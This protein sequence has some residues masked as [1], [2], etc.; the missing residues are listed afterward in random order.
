ML[1]DFGLASSRSD[2]RATRTG[3]QLG[4]L[5][6]MAPEALR[7]EPLDARSDVYAL[8]VTLYELL[9]LSPPYWAK[10]GE[11]IRRQIGE[12]MPIPISRLNPAV[13]RD[14]ETVA[15]AAMDV[16]PRRRYA[17]AAAF[18]RDLANV[19]EKR[20]IEA[21]PVGAFTRARRWLE[22]HPAAGVAIGAGALLAIGAPLAYGVVQARAREKLDRAYTAEK[23]SRALAEKNL[24]RARRAVDTFLREVSSGAL[25]E[26]PRMDQARRRLLERALEFYAE[27]AAEQP[28]D[29][30]LA[31]EAV[32]ASIQASTIL[33]ELSRTEEALAAVDAGESLLASAAAARAASR[34]SG[35]VLAGEPD[36]RALTLSARLARQRATCQ[37][38]LGDLEGADALA[39]RTLDEL[40]RAAEFEPAAS[41]AAGHVLEQRNAEWTRATILAKLGRVGEARA[42]FEEAIGLSERLLG[43]AADSGER[44]RD[45][46]ALLVAHSNL[47][48]F[49]V[50]SGE[51]DAARAVLE[52]GLAHGAGYE[53]A[54]DPTGFAALALADMHVALGGVE[55]QSG[56]RDSGEQH[57]RTGIALLEALLVHRPEFGEARELLATAWNN[58]A[59]ILDPEER[60]ADRALALEKALVELRRLVALEPGVPEHRAFL[61]AS[62]TNRGSFALSAKDH[63]GAREAFEEALAA[64]H[65]ALDDSPDEALFL[66]Y[67]RDVL[68]Y[69]A[70]A[71]LGLDDHRAAW[72]AAL[73]M[74][75]R[76][77]DD[78]KIVDRVVTTAARAASRA[79]RDP[80]LGAGEQAALADEYLARGIAVLARAAGHGVDVQEIIAGRGQFD[81]L[82]AHPDYAQAFGEAAPEDAAPAG[83]RGQ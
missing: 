73:E 40:A 28:R 78:P 1:S 4:S 36:A 23:E 39:A 9:T 34:E 19:L 16:D 35:E 69:E 59:T 67:L 20:P 48:S 5:P 49:L 50:A 10:D 52:R 33:H 62:L 64:L 68:W 8:G 30:E 12:G 76:W 24:E 57:A 32:E 74:D 31:L 41:G 44:T 71:C 79:A 27:V 15:L 54:D 45:L 7:G 60:A 38:E 42:H 21:R 65:S 47:G 70:L 82:R 58:L 66:A 61:A 18:A 43:L 75:S 17:G 25:A 80:A 81:A 3:S 83:D 22:R 6:Y 37:M 63:L 11:E 77:T 51:I 26:L 13:P 53:T 46:G 2:S 14:L 29:P 72:A 56:A 55:H